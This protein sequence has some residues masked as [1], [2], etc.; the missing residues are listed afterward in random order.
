MRGIETN[1]AFIYEKAEIA[2]LLLCDMIEQFIEHSPFE[3]REH[4]RGAYL[5]MSR[6]VIVDFYSCI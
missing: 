2:I 4:K 5:C 1:L 3:E 6:M